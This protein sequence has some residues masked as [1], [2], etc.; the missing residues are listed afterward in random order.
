VYLISDDLTLGAWLGRVPAFALVA[1]DALPLELD[2][3]MAFL[4]ARLN[5]ERAK[6]VVCSNIN[7]RYANNRY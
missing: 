1:V 7:I 2:V 6:I 5:R 3:A 4:R